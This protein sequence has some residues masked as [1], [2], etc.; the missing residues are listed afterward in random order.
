MLRDGLLRLL[1]GA[2]EQ[3]CAATGDRFLNDVVS[4]VDECQRLLQVNDVDAVALG[5]DKASHLWVPAAGLVTEVDT[6]VQ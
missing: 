5:E 6:A 4:G 2:D 3:D 1:L